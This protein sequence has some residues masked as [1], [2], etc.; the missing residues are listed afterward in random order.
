MIMIIVTINITICKNDV[1]GSKKRFSQARL[2]ENQEKIER[3]NQSQ[4]S[5]YVIW[6]KRNMNIYQPNRKRCI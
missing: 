4:V 6:V 3:L 1:S 5:N 2:C